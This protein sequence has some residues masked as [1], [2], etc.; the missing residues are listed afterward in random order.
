MMVSRRHALGEMASFSTK[1]EP[2][3]HIVILL[4]ANLKTAPASDDVAAAQA[5]RRTPW[6]CF[7]LRVTVGLQVCV[8]HG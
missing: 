1:S 4:A 3:H 5:H 2:L 6:V 8:Q 7:G